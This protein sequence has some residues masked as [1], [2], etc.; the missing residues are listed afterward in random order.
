MPSMRALLRVF[1]ITAS[2]S[3]CVLDIG[4]SSDLSQHLRGKGI[5]IEII[6]QNAPVLSRAGYVEIKNEPEVVQRIIRSLGMTPATETQA[7][8][9]CVQAVP[10]AAVAVWLVSGR[11]SSLRV[12]SGTQFE[13]LCV[14]LS[15][16]LRAFIVA[17]Y[18][19]G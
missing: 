14:V 6:G 8:I 5:E 17:E 1:T 11:P 3:G 15:V 13:Y 9:K 4:L 12:N 2:I 16:N 10:H 7:R 18:S 19:Y